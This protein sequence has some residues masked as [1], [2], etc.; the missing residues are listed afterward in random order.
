VLYFNIV[1]ACWG[2]RERC[3]TAA[4]ILKYT[5]TVSLHRRRGWPCRE[6]TARSLMAPPPRAETAAVAMVTPGRPPR[7]SYFSLS[8][9][10]SPT[11]SQ[12]T[13]LSVL[14]SLAHIIISVG[15]RMRVYS[16]T[17]RGRPPLPPPPSLSRRTEVAFFSTRRLTYRYLYTI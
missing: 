6:F 9:S 13:S 8:L 1:Y 4:I 7:G 11:H 17:R 16:R 5:D 15:S 10:L 3:A 14:F 2:I 12:K